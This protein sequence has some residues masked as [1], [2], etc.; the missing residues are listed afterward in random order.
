MLGWK[1]LG[2]NGAEQYQRVEK[3]RVE[4]A[5]GWRG[6]SALHLLHFI[7][8]VIPGWTDELQVGEGI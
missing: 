8:A 7:D 4:G 3:K 6:K 2:E 5:A 1:D